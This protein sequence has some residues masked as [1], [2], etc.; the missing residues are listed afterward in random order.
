MTADAFIERLLT[1]ANAKAALAG[2][3]RELV[4]VA[5][6]L[7]AEEKARWDRLVRQRVRGEISQK[8]LLHP[9]QN[10]RASA[11]RNALYGLIR[12]ISQS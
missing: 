2:T 8:I 5:H 9:E 4:R 10:E 12:E 3:R 11:V 6:A 1:E 7:L